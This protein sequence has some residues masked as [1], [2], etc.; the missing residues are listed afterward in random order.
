MTLTPVQPPTAE[1]DPT[2]LEVD[3]GTMI[4]GRYSWREYCNPCAAHALKYGDWQFRIISL[5][6]VL[7]SYRQYRCSTCR[8]PLWAPDNRR[9][10]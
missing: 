6:E 9:N 1:V 7:T 5:W 8:K 4:E 2:L 3:A 10:P